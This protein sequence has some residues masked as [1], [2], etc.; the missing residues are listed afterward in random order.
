MKRPTY[1]IKLSYDCWKCADRHYGS[2][3]VSADDP[4]SAEERGWELAREIN[5]RISLEAGPEAWTY[6]Y[7]FEGVKLYRGDPRAWSEQRNQVINAIE[8]KGGVYVQA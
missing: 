3:Y 1:E 8:K 5:E 7:R 2:E 4:I 6:D